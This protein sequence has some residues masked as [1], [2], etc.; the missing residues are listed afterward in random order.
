MMLH[1]MIY[2]DFEFIAMMSLTHL[3]IVQG[4]WPGKTD[5]VVVWKPIRLRK[6]CG[7]RRLLQVVKVHVVLKKIL[8]DYSWLKCLIWS[9]YWERGKTCALCHSNHKPCIDLFF[10][11]LTIDVLRYLY[12]ENVSSEIWEYK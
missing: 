1:L 11:L 9:T 5:T 8:L 12:K 4:L 3:F 6:L 7:L 2:K 10:H